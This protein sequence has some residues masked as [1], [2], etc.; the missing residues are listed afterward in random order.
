MR[1]YERTGKTVKVRLK[2][3]EAFKIVCETDLLED[4]IGVASEAFELKPFE[5]KTFRLKYEG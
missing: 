3:P 4:E 5:I 2:L 1:I